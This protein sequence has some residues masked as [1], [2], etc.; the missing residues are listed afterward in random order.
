MRGYSLIVPQGGHNYGT[1]N[2]ELPQSLEWLNRRLTP[3]VP[4]PELAV[5][6]S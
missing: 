2:R 1:W 5:Q 3:A 6:R 4:Q